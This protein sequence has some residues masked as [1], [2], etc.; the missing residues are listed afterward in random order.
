MPWDGPTQLVPGR[1]YLC[2]GA[3]AVGAYGEDLA[4]PVQ[5]YAWQPAQVTHAS[6]VGVVHR[7]QVPA[8][9]AYH[10]AQ[11]THMHTDF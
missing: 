1:A 3:C 4:G 7:G 6:G 8:G 2:A 9:S 11:L 5:L 10:L